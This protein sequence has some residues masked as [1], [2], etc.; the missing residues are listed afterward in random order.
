MNFFEF[1]QKFP[2]QEAVIQHFIRIRY[3]ENVFCSRCGSVSVYQRKDRPKVFQCDSCNCGFSVFKDTIFEN[4][5]TDLRIWM[6][7]I[8]LFLN[9]KKGISGYQLQRETGVTYKTAWRILKQIRL[10]MGNAENQEFIDTVIEIDETY[11][12]GKPRKANRRDD[13]DDN[14]PGRGRGTKKTAV[15]GVIDRENKKA[16]VRV[17]KPNKM[18]KKLTGKQLLSILNQVV[19]TRNIVITD[20]FRSYNALKDTNHIHLRVNHSEAFALGEVH[21][22]NIE[23]FWATLKRGILGI[24]HHVSVEYLQSYINEFCFRYNHRTH[25]NLTNPAMFDMVLKQAVLV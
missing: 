20:E 6:Y 2:T 16:H 22:N 7:A 15:V 10:A 25:A 24:Y 8:H 5:P 11:V 9:G 12:G 4:S 21:T 1:Q 23:S 17:A 13:D 3:G 14:K 18:G 19:K